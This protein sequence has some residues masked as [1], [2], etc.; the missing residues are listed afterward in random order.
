MAGRFR[1]YTDADINGPVVTALKR[2]GWDVLRAV[3]AYP[4]KTPD[5]VHFERAAAEGRVFV[6]NDRR[7]EA[8]AHEWLAQGRPFRA[9]IC[10]PRSHY[11]H[12]SPG[13]FVRAFEG[14]ALQEDA[15]DPYPIH[16]LRAGR[17]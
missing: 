15:F 2:R 12:M 16:H 11:R 4:E 7:L 17:Q 3:D 14:L 6:T 5:V 8:I 9:L 1:I 10:W 13:D